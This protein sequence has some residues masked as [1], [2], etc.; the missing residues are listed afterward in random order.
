MNRAAGALLRVCLGLAAASCRPT[1]APP[2]SGTL[3][4]RGYLWQRDWR[5]PVVAEAWRAAEARLAGVVVLGGEIVWENGSPRLVR[6]ELPWELLRASK[7][8]V[9]L[10]LRV[11]PWANPQG[12]DAAAR[13]VTGTARRLVQEAAANRVPLGELQLDFDCAQSK[14]AGYRAW[15]RAVRAAIAPVPLVITALPAWLDEPAFPKLVAEVPA[16]VLQVHSVPLRGGAKAAAPLSLC[17]PDSARR[18]VAQAGK[19]GRPFFAALPTYRCLGGY[20][21]DGHL[22][23]VAMDSVQ[24]AWPGGTRVLE[25]SSDADALAQLVQTWQTAR[26]AALQ[27]LIWYR[28]PC[29]RDRRNW[30]WPTLAAVMQGRPPTHALELT[31]S[32]ENPIDVSVRNRGEA[33]ETLSARA[34]ITWKT[35]ALIASDALAGWQVAAAETS[36]QFVPDPVRPIRLL[37]GEQRA[38][39]WL[40]YEN[41]PARLQLSLVE[42]AR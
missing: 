37:P 4:Q 33:E 11:A 30:G 18:W 28:V 3:P 23:G 38:I 40:R 20:A 5:D 7:N 6:A 9:G 15:V 14:L 16:Y 2:V 27:G 10:G 32:G 22:L 19:I 34:V 42:G 25:F 35:G 12:D 39:G 17:D 8:P 41:P 13:F 1:A 29:E 21:P 31:T 24:P 36:A 26:P